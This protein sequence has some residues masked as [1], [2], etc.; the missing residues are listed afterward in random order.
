MLIIVLMV[1][2]IV[3]IILK[4]KKLLNYK[5]ILLILLI[6]ILIFSCIRLI[7]KRHDIVF[8]FQSL[9]Y[10]NIDKYDYTN[11]IYNN[12]YISK[13]GAIKIAKERTNKK[14]IANVSCEL[15]ENG[16]YIN[17]DEEFKNMLNKEDNNLN[18]NKQATY[19]NIILT[20]GWEFGYEVKW[21]F[22][23]DYYTGEI[24]QWDAPK[25]D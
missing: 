4:K 25:L 20:T 18:N 17:Y 10:E 23:I 8:F 11:D 21:I 16:T 5:T 9:K 3:L 24:L 12:G 14:R 22:K 7:A 6:C 15:V 1:M 2:A 19:W 13:E